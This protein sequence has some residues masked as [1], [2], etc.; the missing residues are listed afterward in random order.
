MR[1]RTKN[2]PAFVFHTKPAKTVVANSGILT[3]QMGEE[4]QIQQCLASQR[5]WADYISY[6]YSHRGKN[7]LIIFFLT[8]IISRT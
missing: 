4:K 8:A 1:Y 7:T 6:P 2:R 5:T 3:D